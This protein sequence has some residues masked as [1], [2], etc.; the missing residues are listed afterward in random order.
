MVTFPT[1]SPLIDSNTFMDDFAAGAENYDTITIYYELT[2][3]M[4]L[5]NFPLA[6]W[7][8]NLDQLKANGRAEGQDIEA[9]TQVL[10]VKW[11]TETDCFFNPEAIN[12]GLPEGL[13]TK[14]RLLQTTA[15]LCDPLGFYCPLSVV[16]KLLFQDTWHRGID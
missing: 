6:K 7:A 16:G 14:R 1:A 13:T 11:N 9:Q 10:G 2:A 5:I 3:L 8:S 12:K 4:K 15:R